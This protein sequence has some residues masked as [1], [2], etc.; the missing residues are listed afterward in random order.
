MF[1]KVLGKVERTAVTVPMN[2]THWIHIKNENKY[3]LQKDDI[4]STYWSIH[5]Y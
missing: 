5:D 4:V 3:Q 2:N 1:K